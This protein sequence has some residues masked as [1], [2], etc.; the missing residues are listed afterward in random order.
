MKLTELL[1]ILKENMMSR[2]IADYI[3]MRK[4]KFSV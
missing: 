3:K 4:F 1:L 2:E